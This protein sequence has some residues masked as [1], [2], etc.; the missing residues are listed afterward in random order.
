MKV[1]GVRATNGGGKTHVVREVMRI[2]D[3]YFQKKMKLSNGVLINVYDNF[4]VLGSYD[5]ACG[6]CDTIKTPALVWDSIMECAEHK[7]VLFEGIL[8]GTVY[9]PTMD[10]VERLKTIDTT[11]IPIC[12]NTSFE[13]SVANVNSRRAEAGKGEIEKLVNIETNY[14][15]HISSAKKL[16]EAG[17]NPHW[18]SAEEAINIILEEFGYAN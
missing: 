2:T 12:L 10:L 13:Q 6:G 7:N 17:L 8:V 9:Q 16:K 3:P 15:K 18:V 1:I 4:V 5:R 11:Y 14:K